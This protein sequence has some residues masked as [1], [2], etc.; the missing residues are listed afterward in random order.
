M[1]LELLEQYAKAHGSLGGFMARRM[2]VV[3]DDEQLYT[4]L[5]GEAARTHRPAKEI[6]AEAVR[7]WLEAQEDAEDLAVSRERMLAYRKEGGV[8]LEEVLRERGLSLS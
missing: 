4:A 3:F 1:F 7:Q 8:H 5:K 2:T 6:V